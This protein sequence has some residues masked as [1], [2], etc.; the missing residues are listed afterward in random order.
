MEE[1]ST[2][3][4]DEGL[5]IPM[6]FNVSVN[7]VYIGKYLPTT[8]SKH[9]EVPHL[10]DSGFGEGKYQTFGKNDPTAGSPVASKRPD[11]GNTATRPGWAIGLK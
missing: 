10:V 11:I 9:Y 1:N 3:E 5:Q 7:F 6:Y 4:L 2:W 8:L